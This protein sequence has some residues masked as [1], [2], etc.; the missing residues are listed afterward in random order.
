MSDG[1]IQREPFTWPKLEKLKLA[2]ETTIKR[3][4]KMST[5]DIDLLTTET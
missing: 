5:V 1:N 4:L 3:E 2:F